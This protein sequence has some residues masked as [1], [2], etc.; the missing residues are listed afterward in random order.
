MM[1]L[2]ILLLWNVSD[3]SIVC[4]LQSMTASGRKNLCLHSFYDVYCCNVSTCNPSLILSLHFKTQT[5]FMP[6]VGIQE[7]NGI[8]C[9]SGGF[10]IGSILAPEK[11]KIYVG[12]QQEWIGS[13]G[14]EEEMRTR[15][16]LWCPQKAPLKTGVLAQWLTSGPKL[17]T[18][19]CI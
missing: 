1:I 14:R 4:I 13:R 10:L 19:L 12:T 6:T 16:G 15:E 9:I 17:Q 11:K 5:P 8:M 18:D 7:V 2:F 3:C